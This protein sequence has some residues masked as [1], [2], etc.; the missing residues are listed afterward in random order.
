[1]TAKM[2]KL[3]KRQLLGRSFAGFGFVSFETFASELRFLKVWTER[4]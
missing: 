3:T 2:T 1:M 4:I